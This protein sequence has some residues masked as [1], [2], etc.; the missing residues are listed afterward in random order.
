M[1]D[2]L[3]TREELLRQCK[4]RAL[5]ELKFGGVS[6]AIASMAQ[7]IQTH[8]ATAM[9]PKALSFLVLAAMMTPTEDEI[10][11]WIEGFN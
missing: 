1:E 9:D 5:S 8:P 11:K 6:A 10:I 3:R 2:E 4:D 7:D